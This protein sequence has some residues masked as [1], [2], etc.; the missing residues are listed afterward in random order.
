MKNSKVSKRSDLETIPKL[1]RLLK[2]K[3]FFIT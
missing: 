1:I 2:F 3:L